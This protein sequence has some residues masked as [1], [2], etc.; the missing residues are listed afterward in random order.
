[1]KEYILDYQEVI[2]SQTPEE[3]ILKFLNETYDTGAK[4]AGWNVES[5]KA[6]IPVKP[7]VYG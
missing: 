3:S 2:D 6:E 5:L 4:A 1:M 7:Q